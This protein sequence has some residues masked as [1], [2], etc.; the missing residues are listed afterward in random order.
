MRLR[1]F[2][3]L[4]I[5]L[6]PAWRSDEKMIIL[7]GRKGLTI[8]FISILI[9]LSCKNE[10]PPVVTTNEV[11]AI[12][13]NSATCGG[14]VVDEGSGTVF[15]RGVCW[16]SD[17]TPTTRDNKSS[18]G[19]GIGSFTSNITG[20]ESGKTYNVRA[21][22][23]S[24]V[25]TAYGNMVTFDLSDILS[26]VVTTLP[27][28]SV[29]TTIAVSGGDVTY[30]GGADII[31]R[32]LCWSH[33]RAPLVTD[34]HTENGTGTGTFSSVI[35]GLEEGDI[36]YLRAYAINS[37]DTAY[38]N[39]ISFTTSVSDADNNIYR[40][41]YIG[42]KIWMAENMRTTRYNDGSPIQLEENNIVWSTLTTG[43]YCW[44]N[45]DSTYKYIYG[46][47]YNWEV[48]NTG[49]ICHEG[50]RIAYSTEWIT[51]LAMHLGGISDAGG[52]MKSIPGWNL[53][54]TGAS[55]ESGFTALPGGFRF[56]S[57]G[58]F[59]EVG[60][61]GNWWCA[62]EGK[63]FYISYNSSQLFYYFTNKNDGLSVRCIRDL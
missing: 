19:G 48:V 16:A 60:N 29:S 30:D 59:L 63:S 1:I 8:L 34:Y 7:N 28:D 32:G 40:T 57:D 55:N 6:S 3:S 24:N 21:Y 52:K 2:V 12:L 14:K 61:I 56:N 26:P 23:T 43:A 54:N 58:S 27:L 41:T 22:A 15:S 11:T 35:S 53:P 44:Y 38:G 36:Y 45:N 25:G 37:M 17:I 20:L 18:D 9:F 62:E 50:W 31:K 49:K 47:L 39:Q 33:T 4:D 42:N 46:A 10:K 5:N 51:E 13:A